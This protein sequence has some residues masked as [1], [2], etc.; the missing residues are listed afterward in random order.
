MITM[1]EAKL[2]RT[3]MAGM[4]EDAYADGIVYKTYT[5]AECEAN[6]ATRK[7]VLTSRSSPDAIRARNRRERLKASGHDYLNKER[8]RKKL[9]RANNPGMTRA[10]FKKWEQH[11]PD[12]VDNYKENRKGL[13]RRG[14]FI[15]IDS[16]GQ[17]YPY[18]DKVE[19]DI[20]YNG[21]VFPPHATYLWGAYSHETKTPLYLTDP[22]SKGKVKYKLSVKAIFDWLLND[23]KKTY[24]DANYVMFG[25][26]YDMSQLF[27][28]LPHDVSYEIFKGGR[29]EDEEEFA[30][31]VFWGEYAI[32]L[33]QSKWLILWRLRDH[34]KPYKMDTEGSFILD[35]KGRMQLDTVQK[36]QI[37]ETF[38]YFQ[39]GFAKVV[40]DMMKE[41][42]SSASK[43]LLELNI[44]EEYVNSAEFET[45][46]RF[47][48]ENRA[49]GLGS[50][51]TAEGE[52]RLYTM[53][54]RIEG[55]RRYEMMLIAEK[56]RVVETELN[57]LSKDAALI[58]EF[59]PLR[60]DFGSKEIE[61]IREYMTGELRQLSVRM[62]QIRQTLEKLELF[63]TSWHGP[64]AVA[65]ALIMKY[66]IRDHFGENISTNVTPNSPQYYA[67]HSFAGGRIELTPAR[68]FKGGLF[69]GLRSI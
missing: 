7:A 1:G 43:Q 66:K 60:G 30:A 59:K 46:T 41:Q 12:W 14:E 26:S 63:P 52:L 8:T 45:M 55:E 25:M 22:R 35:K 20:V 36:I 17:D 34:N 56:R 29:F 51:Y 50:Y 42:K 58:K 11:N 44:R 16:E 53:E 33:V 48:Y 57:D 21:V 19:K 18:A 40:E 24:R 27:C 39:T 13:A 47:K 61:P 68:V 9:I 10:S 15:P 3:L 38:G 49:S 62:E 67:H 28:Q 32:K 31:P 64:G 37:Y 69:S 4:L 23:V 5:A 65:S 2:K 6:D 54:Q